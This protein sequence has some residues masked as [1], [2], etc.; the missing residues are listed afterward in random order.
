MQNADF[1][2]NYDDIRIT[3]FLLAP[4]MCQTLVREDEHRRKIEAIRIYIRTNNN[5]LPGDRN[6]TLSWSNGFLQVHNGNHRLVA[7]AL[8]NPT[9]TYRDIREYVSF[10]HDRVLN[11]QREYYFHVYTNQCEHSPTIRLKDY[12]SHAH[13]GVK[14]A[15]T[16]T[17]IFFRDPN[18]FRRNEN[19][20]HG[21]DTSFGLT[22][23]NVM[24]AINNYNAIDFSGQMEFTA[25]IVNQTVQKPPTKP[26]PHF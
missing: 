5:R 18:I 19:W 11:E 25:Q 24:H 13:G 15:F 23:G 3:N 16:A 8:E 4:K 17:P 21:P 1:I 6:I 14:R 7:L 10:L 12:H 26:V 20:G 22:I 9:A 2:V